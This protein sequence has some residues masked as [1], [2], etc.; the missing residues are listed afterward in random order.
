MV[1]A[2]LKKS[3]IL[4]SKHN[5]VVY[6]KLQS[7]TGWVFYPIKLQ[8]SNQKGWMFQELIRLLK[9]LGRLFFIFRQVF[10]KT[11]LKQGQIKDV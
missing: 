7:N 8:I 10:N 5:C 2:G 3:S 11:A 9:V 4:K 1:S 6:H